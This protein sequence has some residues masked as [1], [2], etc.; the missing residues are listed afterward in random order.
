MCLSTQTLPCLYSTEIALA[1][2]K[3]LII[4]INAD[5][6]SVAAVRAMLDLVYGI[7]QRNDEP[8]DFQAYREYM[9]SSKAAKYGLRRPQI[10]LLVNNRTTHL[11]T[12]TQAETRAVK[13]FRAMGQ[14][15]LQVLFEAYRDHQEN[16]SPRDEMPEINT[17]DKF[18]Q[19]YFEDIRDFHTTAILCLHTGCPLGALSGTVDFPDTGASVKV[20]QKKKKTYLECLERLV[21]KL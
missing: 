20:D 12:Q 2:A 1:A 3:K 8:E 13:G 9:F 10:H 17:I 5:D 19:L 4:P 15:N 6:F 16:F 21:G 18:Q 7:R 14:K 11:T